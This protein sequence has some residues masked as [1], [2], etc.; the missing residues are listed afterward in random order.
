MGHLGDSQL[1]QIALKNLNADLKIPKNA[2]LPLCP[3]SIEGKMSH[4]SFKPVDR[5]SV[6]EI[7]TVG[8]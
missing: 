4:Q 7:I 2:P 3:R 1:R 8:R 6:Y 5:Y